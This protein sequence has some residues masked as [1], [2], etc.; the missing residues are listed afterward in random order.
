MRGG[1]APKRK[2]TSFERLVRQYYEARGYLVV[3]QGSSG[4][5]RRRKDSPDDW[6]GLFD[7]LIIRRTAR[8]LLLECKAGGKML[9]SD[10]ILLK[11][12]ADLFEVDAAVAYKRPKTEFENG[13]ELEWINRA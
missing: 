8:P 7:L 4:R 10:K 1:A 9:G 11:R 6:R 13:F 5:G 2:G 3:R 12:V